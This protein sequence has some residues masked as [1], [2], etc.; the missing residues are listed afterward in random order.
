M[1]YAEARVR[2]ELQAK[3]GFFFD[4]ETVREAARR[5]CNN[6]IHNGV[7]VSWLCRNAFDVAL[8]VRIEREGA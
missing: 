3:W 8:E 1:R 4:R 7:L 6:P 2:K 5:I